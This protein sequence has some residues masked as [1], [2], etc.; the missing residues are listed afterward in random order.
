MFQLQ[1][2]GVI[3]YISKDEHYILIDGMFFYDTTACSL[4]LQLNDKIV[5]LCY[6]DSKDSLVIVRILQNQ[7]EHWGDFEVD[8]QETSYGVVEHVFIGEVEFR[9]DRWVI[10]KESDL[11]FS[12]DNVVGTFVPIQGDLLELICK[13][14]YDEDNPMDITHNNVSI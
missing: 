1:F 6:K 10:I 3:T 5:Y 9:D 7:G 2:S 13:V 11:K 4:N 12:L 8:V 14:K